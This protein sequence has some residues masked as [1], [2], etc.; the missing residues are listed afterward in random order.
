MLNARKQSALFGPDYKEIEIGD[1]A[2]MTP[3]TP[4]TLDCGA[5]AGRYPLAFRTYGELNEEKS[6][7]VWVFHPLTADQYLAETHPVTGKPGWWSAAVGPGKAVDTNRFFVICANLP[8]G[9]MG[10]WG[11]KSVNPE[12]GEPY[13]LSF[14][15]LTM[16]DM[17]RLQKPLA[18]ALGITRFYAVIGASMG[19]MAAL[20][21]AE[22]YPESA[23]RLIIVAGGYRQTP[24]NIAFNEVGRQAV[25]ADPE[26]RGGNYLTEKTFP[27]KGLAVG[28]M[29]A[30]VSFLSRDAIE[31]KFGRFLQ[32]GDRPA[33]GFGAD[34]RIE[35]YLRHQGA[36]FVA[37]FDPNAFL[38]LTRATDYYDITR[39]GEVSPVA[40]MAKLKHMRVTF[41]SFSSDWRCP[42]KET[43]KLI[44]AGMAA[45]IDISG[46]EIDTDKGHDAFLLDE[47]AFF[48]VL[49]GAML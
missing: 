10:S 34:F 43:K 26:W 22:M 45:G 31:K 44:H 3:E 27:E 37:R 29:S 36:A 7:A 24:Q 48:D 17:A 14:P 5:R 35:S 32:E 21:W 15:V 12:T 16:R 23:E 2:D 49:A 4:V 38:Y 20:E 13:A 19:A 28:R 25:T 9:C 18:D 33:Y 1:I 42:T 30:Y 47:P 11:P 46:V 39:H 6:N 40:L 8:G 41:F